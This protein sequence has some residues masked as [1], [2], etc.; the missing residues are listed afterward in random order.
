VE[1]LLADMGA[2]QWQ[3]EIAAPILRQALAQDEPLELPEAEE[4]PAEE[5]AP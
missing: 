2:R 4:S 1:H 3:I 5:S